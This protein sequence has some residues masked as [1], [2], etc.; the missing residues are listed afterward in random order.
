[1]MKLYKLRFSD[2]NAGSGSLSLGLQ[3]PATLKG[4]RTIQVHLSAAEA[5]HFMRDEGYTLSIPEPEKAE[6]P[7]KTKKKARKADKEK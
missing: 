6:E 4:G 3:K 7:Q 1:M 5:E 2:A